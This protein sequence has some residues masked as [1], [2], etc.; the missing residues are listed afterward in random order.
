MPW[1]NASQDFFAF[2]SI[3]LLTFNIIITKKTYIDK[4]IVYVYFLILIQIL[5]QFFLDFFVLKQDFFLSILY[6][7]LFFLSI[8][9]G[10]YFKKN[11]DEIIKLTIF[12]TIIGFI[13]VLIQILQW[14]SFDSFSFILKSGFLRPS[15][16]I[17][18]PN[19]LATLLFMSFFSLLYLYYNKIINIYF[20]LILDIFFVLGIALTQSRTSWVVFFV[21]LV[22]SF[23]RRDLK[24]FKVIY[25]NA[26]IFLFFLLVLPYKNILFKGGGVTLFERAGSD[27]SR[28]DIWKQIYLAII[29]KPTLGYGWNQTSIAQTK[30]SLKYPLNVWLEYSHNF[31]LDLF[32]W[33]GIP[34]GLIIIFLIV[35]WFFSTFNKIKHTNEL[36][37]FFAIISFFVHCMFEF[38]FAYAYFLVPIGLFIG[39][40]HKFDNSNI[41]F[42]RW[43]YLFILGWV[44]FIF[45]II[46]KDYILIK[47][48]IEK[49]SSEYL[50]YGKVTP[51]EYNIRVL[52]GLDISVDILYLN[53]CYVVNKYDFEN[54]K[55]VF[56]RYPTNKN[57]VAYYSYSVYENRKNSEAL[58][59]MKLRYPNSKNKFNAKKCN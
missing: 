15:A 3:I 39:V 36:I 31:F 57:L 32:V 48:K 45:I 14:F 16:N 5:I 41:Y 59:Y 17:G 54:V 37:I 53:D 23:I 24:L 51:V 9:N 25:I 43:F 13:S 7:N 29:D 46:I 4:N 27:S 50:I 21:L 28:L 6:I 33:V 34:F 12:F 30:T 44:L 38:P 2:V 8:V 10:I 52:D 20:F 40:V 35:R 47:D 26:I 49:Y 11:K 58:D 1:P 55:A 22:L 56:Y 42:D 19:N 18:Q